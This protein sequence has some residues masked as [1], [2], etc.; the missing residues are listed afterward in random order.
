MA[1]F[2]SIFGRTRS[3]YN[4]TYTIQTVKPLFKPF[5]LSAWS[6]EQVAQNWSA[7]EH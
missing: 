5:E 1:S 2:L 4:Q 6:R 7:T 3:L